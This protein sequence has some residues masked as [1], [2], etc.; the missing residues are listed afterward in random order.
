MLSYVML[1]LEDLVRTNVSE[2]CI[3]SIIRVTKI[4]E[5]RKMLAC[6]RGSFTS[7]CIVFIVCNVSFFV[8]LDLCAVLF[9]YGHVRWVPLSPRHGASLG[10][11]W[12]GRP[13]VGG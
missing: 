8:C 2:E 13:P 7:F 1:R 9:E 11:G 4:G 5:L 12:K 10:C 6:Y 3:A